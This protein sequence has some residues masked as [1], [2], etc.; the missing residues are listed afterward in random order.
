[1]LQGGDAKRLRQDRARAQQ[2]AE[3]DSRIQF[4]DKV[5]LK[6][7][8]VS[9][10]ENMT[11]IAIE[12]RYSTARQALE[13]LESRQVQH[14]AA[15]KFPVLR[16]T[17]KPDGTYIK[18][19]KSAEKL[20]IR[21]PAPGLRNLEK[22]G[23]IGLSFFFFASAFLIFMGNLLL[24]IIMNQKSLFTFVIWLAIYIAF[25]TLPLILLAIFLGERTHIYFDRNS[26]EIEREILS[27]KYGLQKIDIRDVS[28]VLLYQQGSVYQVTIRSHYVNYPL[29]GALGE[30]ESAWL[31]Q[32]IQDWLNLR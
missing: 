3:K 10:I 23:C 27:F 9:W 20:K 7:S 18:I 11:E 29:G 19:K 22:T 17:P 21:V 14:K 6:P 4:S 1:M 15:A 28:G 12:K 16:K 5:S 13:A 2:Q 31:A 8:F 25:S 26:I 32:E 30:Q 24:Q